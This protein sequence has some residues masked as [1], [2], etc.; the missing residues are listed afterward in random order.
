MR[1]ETKEVKVTYGFVSKRPNEDNITRAIREMG[2]EGWRLIQRVDE[3]GINLVGFSYT[4]LIFQR[5][6][7]D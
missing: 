7:D 1:Y 5:V 2:A 4:S 3:Q 6:A